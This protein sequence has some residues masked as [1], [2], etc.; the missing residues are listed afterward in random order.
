VVYDEPKKLD[1]YLSWAFISDIDDRES[2][3][4]GKPLPFMFRVN[5]YI[6]AKSSKAFRTSFHIRVDE[7]GSPVLLSVWTFGVDDPN[8]AMSLEWMLPSPPPF[9]TYEEL[10]PIKD[11]VALKA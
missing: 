5:F 6:K 7:D 3:I 11:T 4:S 10:T 9:H 1:D 2:A 8:Q